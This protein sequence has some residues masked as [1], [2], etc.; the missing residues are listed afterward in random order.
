MLNFDDDDGGNGNMISRF[1]PKD[2]AKGLT[3]VLLSY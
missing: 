3:A 1:V 2:Y